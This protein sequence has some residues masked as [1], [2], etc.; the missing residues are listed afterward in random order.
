MFVQFQFNLQL[1]LRI[2][3][4]RYVTIKVFKMVAFLL[5]K[6]SSPELYILVTSFLALK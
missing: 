5:M 1:A 3:I 2:K 4:F 6:T